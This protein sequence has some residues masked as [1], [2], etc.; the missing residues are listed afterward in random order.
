MK[1]SEIEDIELS[2]LLDA[3][4]KIYG[5]DFREYARSSL[6]RRTKLFASYAG[7]N[8][9]SDMIPKLIHEKNF[10]L[11]LVQ[12]FS[13]TVTEMF[14]DPK[15][16]LKLIGSVLPVLETYP[17]IK[18]WHA[19][20]ATGEEVYSLAITLKESGLYNHTTIF[21][22]DFND[23]ALGKARKGIYHIENMKQCI[24]NYQTAGG[25]AS[26]SEYYRAGYESITINKE[27]KKNVTFANHN[28]AT[29]GVFSEVHLILCRNVLIYFNKTL[30]DK[31]LQLFWES[32][33]PGGFLCLGSKESIAFSSV[34][35]NF[36]V[37]EEKEKIFQKKYLN[38]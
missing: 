16:Y 26:F 32:L 8:N 9:I 18:I 1:I 23:D 2:L 24:S 11:D 33:V 29:D 34:K 19:G 36:I 27:I 4:Y 5:Y 31:V 6:L 14:R 37:I 30:Q 35:D 17:Y 38:N 25:S 3:I 12:Y 10:F 15:V 22:T 28:L 7:V 21:A 13:I 20:C